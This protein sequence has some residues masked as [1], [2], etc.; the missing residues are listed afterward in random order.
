M[1]NTNKINNIQETQVLP[2]IF[3]K[4]VGNR[5]KIIPLKTPNNIGYVRFF[6]PSTKE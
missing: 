6:P 2:I 5:S 4:K 1:I 3:T